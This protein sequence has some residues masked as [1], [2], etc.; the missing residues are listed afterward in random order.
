MNDPMVYSYDG[1]LCM[2][3]AGPI[4][5]DDVDCSN[6]DRFQDCTHRG[7]GV[8]NCDSFENIGLIC[9]PGPIGM[10]ELYHSSNWCVL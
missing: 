2:D 5:L 1:S 3:A 10:V 7:W 9:D 8:H 6:A 4:L